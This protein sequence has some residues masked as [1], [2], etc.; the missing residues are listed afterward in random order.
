MKVCGETFKSQSGPINCKL[1]NLLHLWSAN[2]VVRFLMLEKPKLSFSISSIAKK[3]K[4]RAFKK[5]NRTI[6]QK[7]FQ[8]H[9]CLDGH[10]GIDHWDVTLLEQYKTHKQLEKR[11][12]FWLHQIK[13]RVLYINIPS[14][15]ELC[16]HTY[17]VILHLRKQDKELLLWFSVC[18]FI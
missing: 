7:F 9:H 13:R 17:L 5:T 2:C 10:L 3:T 11:Q 15:W 8:K 16:V 6:L 14:V 18:F 4:H 1:E 12:T